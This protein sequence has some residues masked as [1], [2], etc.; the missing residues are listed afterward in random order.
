MGT[1]RIDRG[2]FDADY[3]CVNTF[4]QYNYSHDNNWFCGIMKRPNRNVVIRYNLS[5]NEREGFYFY[6][7]ED[8][9]EAHNIHIYNNTHVVGKGRNVSVFPK[10]RTPINSVFENNIFYFEGEGDWGKNARGLNTT[11]RNNLYFNIEPHASETQPITSHPGFARPGTIGN[12]IDLATMTA[13]QGYRLRPGSPGVDAGLTIE[14][15]GGKDILGTD[16]EA[17]KT[18]VGAVED[19]FTREAR[20]N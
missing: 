11:F 8:E 3:N 12:R 5:Q 19:G 16:I 13:L 20:I 14:E 2:G 18:D 9:Q 10:E 15:S 6:G 4:I 1:E 17:G 7:F